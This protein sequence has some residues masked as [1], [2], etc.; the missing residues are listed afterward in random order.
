MSWKEYSPDFIRRR[1]GRLAAIYP[2]FELVFWLPPGIRRRAVARLE[3]KPG[4]RVLEVG[5]G[6]GRNF[7]HLIRAA[8]ADGQ[9]YGVDF[10]PAMLSVARKRCA[11]HGWQNVT[12]LE[13]DA[14]SLELPQPVDAVLFSLSYA[15][16]PNHREVLHQVWKHL[17][18]GKHLVVL[19]AKSPHGFLG[20]VTRPLGTWVSR[21]SVLGNP[22][23][24]PWD[25]LRELTDSV[26]IG[27]ELLGM[28][29]ICRGTKPASDA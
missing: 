18:P 20:R 28:Y 11:Q 9:V 23:R 1:Y 26:E 29:Y 10:T 5:C 15:V 4:D 19:D 14:A 24:R 22:D 3:L 27:E 17:R 8:G 2:V 25:D 7:P 21:A 13:G 12:L 6:T 16:M